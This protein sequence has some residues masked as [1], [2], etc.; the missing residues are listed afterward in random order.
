MSATWQ[1]PAT[2]VSGVYIALLTRADTGG[3]S[4][5]T[6]VVRTDGSQ[7]DVVFQTSDTTWQAYNSYGGSDFYQGARNG[8]AYKISYNRPFT[9]RG[10]VERP[11]LLLQ[12]RVPDGAVPGEERLRRQL[13][14]RRG[15]A[16]GT[17]PSS[18]NHK[19]FLSVGHDEYWSGD[20]AGQRRGGPRRRREPAVPLRQRGVL[21]D[22]LGADR[23]DGS[24]TA[25][26]TLVTYKETWANAQD[27][28]EHRVDRAPGATPGSPAG[29]RRRRPE[30]ALTGTMYMANC[31]D[32]P[33]RSAPTEGKIAALA[34]HHL[35]PRWPPA[36]GAH[37]RRTRWATS[38]TRTWTTGSGPPG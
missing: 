32:L 18:S 38:P 17:A 23:Q 16:T 34:Q 7:S 1:V 13:H 8:R 26:R 14:Q 31:S 10:G 35:W 2:A 19:V 25:Y 37:W 36:P 21:A 3:H 29:Q 4:H 15:H 28:P 22:P 30:N 24:D 12:Q 27:R 5:I 9:T 20:A 11:R 33:S 6:F